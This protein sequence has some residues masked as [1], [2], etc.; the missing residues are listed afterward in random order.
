MAKQRVKVEVVLDAGATIG[1][2]PTWS[3]DERALYWIDVKK[4]ALHRYDPLGGV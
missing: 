3:A 4:P 2:S 1:E